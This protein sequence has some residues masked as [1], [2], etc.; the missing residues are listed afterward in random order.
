[1]KKAIMYV[2]VFAII[3][4]ALY[5]DWSKGKESQGLAM[6]EIKAAFQKAGIP[7]APVPDA[8]YFTLYG[9]EPFMFEADGSAFAIYVYKS[10]EMI[11]A[12]LEDFEAQTVNVKAV[13][14]EIYKVKNVLIFEA[15]ELT[16]PS[17]K[18]QKAIE[19][20]KG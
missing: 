20:L 2:L 5:Q 3:V 11:P 4:T 17:E 15:R 1:M 19:N 10:S 18:V 12:A 16:E 14:S 8:T 7:L 13:L 9:K 6:Y